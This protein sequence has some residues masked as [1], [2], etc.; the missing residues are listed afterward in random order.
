MIRKLL[1]TGLCLLTLHLVLIGDGQ[2]E[3]ADSRQGRRNAAGVQLTALDEAQPNPVDDISGY[4]IRIAAW[5]NG[6]DN[7]TMVGRETLKRWKAVEEK[8]NVKLEWIQVPNPQTALEKMVATIL[9]GE[10]FADIVYLEA[11]SVIPALTEKNLVLPL[12]NYFDFTAPQWRSSAAGYPVYKGRVYGITPMKLGGGSGIWYNK[13]LFKR[14]GLP[15][16]HQLQQEGRWTWEEY[17][18]IAREAT[19]DTD[20]DGAVDQWGIT[21]GYELEYPLIWSN[22]ARV[23]EESTDG[24]FRFALDSPQAIEALEFISRIYES[25]VTTHGENTFIAGRAAMYGGELFQGRNMMLNMQDEYGFVFFPKGPRMND[26]VSV[27]NAPLMQ[28]FPANLNFPPELLARIVEE[29]TPFELEEEIRMEFL[30]GQLTSRDDI[31][32]VLEMMN[33]GGISRKSSFPHLTNVA[34]TIFREIRKGVSPATAVE[35][36][37]QVGQSAIDIVFQ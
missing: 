11:S 29:I 4:T 32:T 22:G 15:D 10:P 31:A 35:E 27:G 37:K 26:Y 30:E 1:Y 13:S 9:I 19:R 18:R 34:G 12:D 2:Q 33:K 8:Y 3:R 28:V 7:L 5:W 6:P 17:L 21:I 25:G 20:G 23:V 24:K 14:E 36:N 16:L